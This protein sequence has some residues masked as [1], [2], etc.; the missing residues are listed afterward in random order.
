[1]LMTRDAKLHKK[2]VQALL[3]A[4]AAGVFCSMCRPTNSSNTPEWHNHIYRIMQSKVAN[5]VPPECLELAHAFALASLLLLTGHAATFVTTDF[6]AFVTELVAEEFWEDSPWKDDYMIK[7]ASGAAYDDRAPCLYWLARL[8]SFL[9][10]WWVAGSKAAQ[11]NSK[12]RM[13]LGKPLTDNEVFMLQVVVCILPFLQ[14][15]RSNLRAVLVMQLCVQ[16]NLSAAITVA[17]KSG[18][19][20]S[21]SA[22]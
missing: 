6:F 7:L 8:Q 22:E 2:A 15:M 3:H 18:M 19:P 13:I 16:G 10:K 20:V 1:M 9:G 21:L 4:T 12:P 14:S 11:V 17:R 5:P